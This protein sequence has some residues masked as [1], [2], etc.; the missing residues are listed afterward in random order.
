MTD[1]IFTYKIFCKQV[2]QL[3]VICG[4]INWM[5]V[6]SRAKCIECIPS[7]SANLI[8]FV[9]I[10][11]VI[12]WV[13]WV[14]NLIYA[15]KFQTFSAFMFSITFFCQYFFLLYFPLFTS[16]NKSL[17][18]CTF[19]FKVFLCWF[20]LDT[21]YQY[22]FNFTDSSPWYP[23]LLLQLYSNIF[24]SDFMYFNFGIPILCTL[25]PYLLTHCKQMFN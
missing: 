17:K 5:L 21:F 15:I 3:V 18:F 10:L 6:C 1:F 14:C 16:W 11:F 7:F 25:H 19:F 2:L 9:F 20:R 12:Y 4:D 23:I 22:L 24:I 8:L 13:P